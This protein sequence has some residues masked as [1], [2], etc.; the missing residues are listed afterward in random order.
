MGADEFTAGVN[1]AMGG[2]CGG[3]MVSALESSL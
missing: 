2:R 1:P 3:L